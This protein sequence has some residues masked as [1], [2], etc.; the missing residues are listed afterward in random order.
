MTGGEKMGNSNIIS[1]LGLVVGVIGLAAQLSAPKCP[2]CG[3]KLIII[4][5]YCIKCNISWNNQ[6]FPKDQ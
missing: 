1:A 6:L 3:S 2:S 5:N 4:N